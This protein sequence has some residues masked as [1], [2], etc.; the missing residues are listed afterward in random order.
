MA[1]VST[2]SSWAATTHVLPMP[3]RPR[4]RGWSC[5]PGW[6]GSPWRRSSGSRRVGLGADQ[7]DGLALAASATAV[8]ESKTTLPRRPGL[9]PMPLVR[10]AVAVFSSKRGT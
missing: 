6:S 4:R 10:L 5:R 2:T 3:G 9:A 7:D 8:G 1:L